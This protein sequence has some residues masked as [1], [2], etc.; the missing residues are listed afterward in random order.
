MQ[1]E[2]DRPTRGLSPVLQRFRHSAVMIR[3]LALRDRAFR[4]L[5]EDLALA[6]E[7]LASFEARGDGSH[8]AEIAEYRSI[9]RDLDGEVTARIDGQSTKSDACLPP[10][11]GLAA[12]DA[13]RRTRPGDPKDDSRAT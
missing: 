7:M 5:C 8:G 4:D 1:S 9:V 13:D 12:D 2:P 3:E 10:S 6:L 11:Q